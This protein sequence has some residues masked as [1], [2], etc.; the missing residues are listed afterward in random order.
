MKGD[1]VHFWMSDGCAWI[2]VVGEA[3]RWNSTQV[4]EFAKEKTREGIRQFMVDMEECSAVDSTF[5]GT[6]A[7]IALRLKEL[8][9]PTGSLRLL[10]MHPEIRKQFEKLGLDRLFDV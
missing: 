6:L 3:T 10:N 7:G 4:K 2:R 5:M 9:A 1:P 8:G